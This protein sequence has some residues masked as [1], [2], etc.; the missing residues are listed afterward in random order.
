M[1]NKNVFVAIALSMSV[2]L[3]WGA[4]VEQP[5][6]IKQTAIKQNQIEKKSNTN[7]ISPNINDTLEIKTASRDELIK[8]VKRVKIENSSIIGSISL[9]GG[10]IDDVSFKN[11]QQNLND[12]KN[13]VFLNPQETEN[14]FFVETG[15]TSIGNK[16]KVPSVNSVWNVKGNNTLTEN[17][18]I[19]LEW[20]NGE[21]ITFKKI[22]DLDNK[23]LFNI[24]QVVENNTNLSI[25][26]YPYAQITRNKIPDDIQNFYISHEGF[27]GVFDEELKEDDYDD[28]EEKK[29]TREA[30]KGWLG[31]TDK[32]WLAAVV[33]QQGESFKSTFLY[34]ESFKANYILNS[35]TVIKPSSSNS[36]K[37]RLFV[38]A[39]EVETIDAY[40]ANQNIEKLDL[41]IDWGWFYF[42]TKPLFFIIDYL[43]KIS[44]NFGI[45]IVLIT[46][47]IRLLFFPLANY[48]FRSMAKMK[49]LQPEMVRLKEIYKDD[50]M[51]L[52]QEMMSLYKKEKVNPASGCLPV[53]IQIPFFFAIYKMLF[54]SL[55]M[56]H[57][58][59]FGWIKDLS[60][61]DPTSLFNF[62]GLIP[63]DP[64]SFLVIGIWPI[65][66]G[67]SMWVQQKLN[68]APTDPIQAK[69]FAFF[70]I[71]LTIIL[72]SFPSGLVVYWTVNNILTIAQQWVIMKKTKIK[73][74]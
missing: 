26:L 33:P 56:R 58:P 40:A 67:L 11:H 25:S 29:I 70:P 19:T 36:N 41:T 17:Q 60:A 52:Q 39:K 35:P 14:G 71:F 73:T 3:F 51:K 72:A 63:W 42:F 69:I 13:V 55:E 74:N 46:I 1:D 59:F 16:I 23:Y 32:Y 9:K 31:I 45:A 48:S 10:L 68:P 43:F 66:M 47:G 49:A 12:K 62:F 18:P 4:F 57:Q 50:K 24:S 53:L 65:L 61:Q 22:I 34:K 28:V 8:N 64:P 15:W 5:E 38:A 44:G 2:L 54:I 21:G 6:N 27:I 7:N 20:D 30:S 37:V